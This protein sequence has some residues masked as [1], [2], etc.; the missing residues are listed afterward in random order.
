MQI[1]AKVDGEDVVVMI[2]AIVLTLSIADATRI[3]GELGTVIRLAEINRENA[4]RVRLLATV[5]PSMRRPVGPM[6]D[7]S[8]ALLR[9]W[10]E[11]VEDIT[12]RPLAP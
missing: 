6:I 1:D 7:S 2:G 3:R 4:A 10:E 8:E 12:A 11:Q 5:P 9:I